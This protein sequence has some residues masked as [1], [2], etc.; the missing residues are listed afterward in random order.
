VEPEILITVPNLRVKESEPGTQYLV[1][2][3]LPEMSQSVE[4]SLEAR[5]R[6]YINE[7]QASLTACDAICL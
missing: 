4:L 6:M 3:E 5:Q 1:E 2:P 7:F